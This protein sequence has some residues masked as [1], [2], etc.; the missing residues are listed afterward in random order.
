MWQHRYSKNNEKADTENT[1]AVTELAEDTQSEETALTETQDN[2]ETAD[3]TAADSEN[4]RIAHQIQKVQK[5]T[6]HL[7]S[8]KQQER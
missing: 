1:E 4:S 8:R 5:K 7:Q 6:A 2:T 3:G